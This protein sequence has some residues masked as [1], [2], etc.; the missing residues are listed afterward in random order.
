[1]HETR[2]GLPMAEASEACCWIQAC[3]KE[4]SS[5]N[6]LSTQLWKVT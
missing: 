5:S 3:W 4:R 6:Q 2:T 1:M